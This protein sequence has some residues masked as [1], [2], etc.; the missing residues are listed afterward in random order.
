MMLDWGW[1]EAGAE[2]CAEIRAR[3]RVCYL[4]SAV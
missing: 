1:V 3:A 2:K 4:G